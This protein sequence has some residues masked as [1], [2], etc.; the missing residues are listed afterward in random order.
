M[1]N[2]FFLKKW[3]FWRCSLV[4]TGESV[5]LVIPPIVTLLLRW[6]PSGL[7]QLQE[8]ASFRMSR[9]AILEDEL[10]QKSEVP[11]SWLLVSG[12]Q[13]QDFSPFFHIFLRG[14]VQEHCLFLFQFKFEILRFKV[15]LK[16]FREVG[17]MAICTGL[18]WLDARSWWIWLR[19]VVSKLLPIQPGGYPGCFTWICHR[20]IGSFL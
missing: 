20:A 9:S 5:N 14:D 10:R 16:G 13:Q 6:I 12:N 11:C 4:N 15:D 18:C 8:S 17:H 7:L 19:L 1:I 3:I 2:I